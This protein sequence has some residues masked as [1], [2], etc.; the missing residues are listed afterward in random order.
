[1]N[2]LKPRRLMEGH[3]KVKPYRTKEGA[4]FRREAGKLDNWINHRRIDEYFKEPTYE[5]LS[6]Y[7]KENINENWPYSLY[8]YARSRLEKRGT[9]HDESHQQAI[10]LSKKAL[11]KAIEGETFG[12]IN[13]F[14]REETSE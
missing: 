12:S 3:K 11:K 6:R 5:E 10:E 13:T 1:M 7:V 4:D 14:I 8:S 9:P 2:P